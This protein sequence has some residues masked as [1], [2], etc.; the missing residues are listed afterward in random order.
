MP[1]HEPRV[2][3]IILNLN[4][5][6][7][8]RD[9]L[10]S[11]RKVD[12]KNFEVVLVD[13]GSA[14]SSADKL[15]EEFREIRIIRNDRNLGFPGGNNVGIQD[16]LGRG[17][18]YVLLLNNDTIVAPDF[19]R[20]LVQVAESDSRIGM[21]NPKIYFCEPADRIWH[22]GGVH[23]PWWSF[24]RTIGVHEQDDGKYNQ[25]REVSFVTGCALL[26]K[27]E[28]VRQ[29][30]LLD[31]LFF[32]GFEDLDW[33]MRAKDAGFI[34]IYAP[35]SMIWH[36][37]SHDTKKMGRPVKDYYATRNSI[38]FARKHMANRYWPLYALS[39]GRFLAYRTAGYLVRAEFDRVNA[40]YRGVWNG[41]FT[42]IPGQKVSP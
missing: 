22:A 4:S 32:L 26:V 41:W 5:Y 3:I 15:A 10:L 2:S 30:G 34:S 7:V 24:P 37:G 39:L 33:F 31:E 1:G 12:Y 42:E 14:D 27:S 40:L 35:S 25:T 36:K 8:T 38:L 13:N 17:P 29:V 11:L 28:V 9:C 6:D 18:D 21:V 16:A 20:E 19:L 23:K